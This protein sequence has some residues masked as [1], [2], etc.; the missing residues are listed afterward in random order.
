ME[1]LKLVHDKLA[2]TG[3]MTRAYY[4]PTKPVIDGDLTDKFWQEQ[5]H[6]FYPLRDM[7]TGNFPKHLKTTVSFRWLPN[8]SALVVGIECFEPKMDKL[9]ESCKDR[10]SM[11]IFSDDNIEIQLESTEGI[12]P[13]I[14]IS[15]AGKIYDHC[16]T[17]NVADL[18]AW[19]KVDEFAVKKYPD[20]W[21]VEALIDAKTIA[22]KKP[23][24]FFPWGVNIC[25]QR[26]AG[27]EPEYYML[28]PSGTSF[29]DTKCMGNL[30]LRK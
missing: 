30:Y 3:P 17:K 14:V 29:K 26:M 6:S 9:N 22:G 19:Y 1:P 5:K 13:K 8:K 16:F 18:P 24:K 21:I 20:R 27:N 28:S 12:R 11:A 23:S 7:I 25:R 4:A 15:S 10:D 2:R